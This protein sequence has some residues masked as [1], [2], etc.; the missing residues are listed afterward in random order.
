VHWPSVAWELDPLTDITDD[1]VMVNRQYLFFV[2]L[3]GVL[4]GGLKTTCSEIFLPISKLSDDGRYRVIR[5][6][7]SKNK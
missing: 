5:A 4:S 6:T 3:M 1:G 2:A 7:L